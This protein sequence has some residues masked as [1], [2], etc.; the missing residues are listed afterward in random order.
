MSYNTENPVSPIRGNANV[1]S[2]PS[3]TL[4]NANL[5]STLR[6]SNVVITKC[7]LQ[8]S[9]NCLKRHFNNKRGCASCLEFERRYNRKQKSI[10]DKFLLTPKQKEV[11]CLY[12]N[13][14][15]IKQISVIL[16]VSAKTVEYHYSKIKSLIGVNSSVLMVHWALKH[17]YIQNHFDG[18]AINSNYE[19]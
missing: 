11:L 6:V 3:D 5:F 12:C 15:S 13:N 2:I 18:E 16:N 8:L 1:L 9:S 10:R 17:G 7:K 14:Y 4:K 19:V